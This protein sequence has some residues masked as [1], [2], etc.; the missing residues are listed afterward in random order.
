MFL[1]FFSFS[2][3]KA[4]R[5]HLISSVI[6]LYLAVDNSL[7]LCAWMWETLVGYQMHFAFIYFAFPLPYLLHTYKPSVLPVA[8]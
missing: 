5:N 8:M 4:E 1:H 6:L 2:Q 7:N 3:R